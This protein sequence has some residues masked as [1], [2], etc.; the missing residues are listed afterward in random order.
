MICDVKLPIYDELMLLD[1]D[2]LVALCLEFLSRSTSK[3]D[4]E[5]LPLLFQ[6][7]QQSK[8]KEDNFIMKFNFH[9]GLSLDI[10]L[11]DKKGKDNL[12]CV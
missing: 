2:K 12:F 8:R 4:E 1:T 9:N 6:L 10:R 3:H 5:N 7:H 11:V